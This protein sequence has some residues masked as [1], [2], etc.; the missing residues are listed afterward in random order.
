NIAIS[1]VFTILLMVIRTFQ[2][3]SFSPN[4]ITRPSAAELITPNE[5]VPCVVPGPP[6]FTRLNPLKNS[7]RNCTLKCS[8]NRLFFRTE[9]SQFLRP[10]AKTS[11]KVLDV[12]PNVKVGGAENMEVLKYPV[13][14]LSVGPLS[15]ALVPLLLGRDPPPSDCVLFTE[16]VSPSGCPFWN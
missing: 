14:R 12:F 1:P 13:S 4:C 8:L 6:K 3:S 5:A 7:A 9:K 2:N 11:G 10:G 15:F 16:V